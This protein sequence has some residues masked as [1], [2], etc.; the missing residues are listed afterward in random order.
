MDQYI[1]VGNGSPIPILGLVLDL[2]WCKTFLH[3][4]KRGKGNKWINTDF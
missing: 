1:F 2:R 4:F 3:R